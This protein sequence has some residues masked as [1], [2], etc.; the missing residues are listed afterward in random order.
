[1]IE[2]A[3]LNSEYRVVHGD[4]ANIRGKMRVGDYH[5]HMA[6]GGDTTA[7]R[8]LALFVLATQGVDEVAVT[9]HNNLGYDAAS[10]TRDFIYLLT[11]K[12]VNIINGVE[13]TA[14]SHLSSG[15]DRH[16][17]IY[18]APRP[19]ELKAFT[20]LP[21]LVSQAA[22]QGAEVFLAHPLLGKGMSVTEDEIDDLTNRGYPFG[23]EVHNGGAAQIAALRPKVEAN[24]N[25]P[26]FSFIERQL[27]QSGSNEKAKE[28]VATYGL[29]G[30]GG[31]DL[32]GG[33]KSFVMTCFP[34]GMTLF[35]AIKNGKS[36]IV[37]SKSIPSPQPHELL[38]GTIGGKISSREMSRRI[39]RQQRG[40]ALA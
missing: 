2:A 24:S 34:A 3:V 26:L 6:G 14:K 30:L 15:E 12:F 8:E 39:N 4:P 22:D 32:H 36:I 10:W 5:R 27:P 7:P 16:V 29:A 38:I 33:G 13:L 37:E 21:R 1:M 28:L 17:L 9:N 31:T 18:N 35:E 19:R 23:L 11:G 20:P 40:V 25:N